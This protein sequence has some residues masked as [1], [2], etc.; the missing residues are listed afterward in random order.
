M[1]GVMLVPYMN[2]SVFQ[3][4]GGTRVSGSS[5]SVAPKDG[6]GRLGILCSMR[7]KSFFTENSGD[8]GYVP[9]RPRARSRRR[10][11]S[12]TPMNATIPSSSGPEVIPVNAARTGP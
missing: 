10:R 11:V 8:I 7:M 5:W 1:I 2:G 12:S 9:V 4:N 6:P 3:K